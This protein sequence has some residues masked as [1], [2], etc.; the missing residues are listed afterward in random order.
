M[1]YRR[2]YVRKSRFPAYTRRY[3]SPNEK[4]EYSYPLSNIIFYIYENAN[5]EIINR[6]EYI[7]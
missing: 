5:L 4:L 3:T 6:T 7:T 2:I 1:L